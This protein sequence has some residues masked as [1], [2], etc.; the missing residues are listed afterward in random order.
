MGSCL[1]CFNDNKK[2]MWC[3]IIGVVLLIVLVLIIL[4][5]YYYKPKKIG[6]KRKEQFKLKESYN[7]ED[8]NKFVDNWI[9]SVRK[10]QNEKFA[11]SR[12]MNDFYDNNSVVEASHVLD[13]KIRY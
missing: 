10:K 12:I 8:I 13:G 1:S 7:P 11:Q 5:V 6:F 3:L 4:V 2:L 9:S